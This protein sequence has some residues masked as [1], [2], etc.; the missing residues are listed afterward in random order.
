MDSLLHDCLYPVMLGANTPCHA[1]VRYMQKHY[2]I[3][4]TVLSGKRALTLRFL[5]SVTLINAP[6]TLSDELLLTIL[7]DVELSG[8]MR[9]PLLVLC[10]EAY[11]GFVNR[12]RSV[13]EARFILRRAAEVLG[14]EL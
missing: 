6:P 14:E 11:A 7:Q 8:G 2:D 9:V 10:D 4:S 3:G 13:L 1:C 5:P 12:N